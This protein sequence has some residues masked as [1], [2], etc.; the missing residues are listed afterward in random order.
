VTGAC[1]DTCGAGEI[2]TCSSGFECTGLASGE[3]VCMPKSS[4]PSGGAPKPVPLESSHVDVT[5][6]GCGCG[7]AE[8]GPFIA[9]LLALLALKRRSDRQSGSAPAGGV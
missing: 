7:A 9:A 6:M 3:R 4:T 8:S 5:S 2:D 1:R